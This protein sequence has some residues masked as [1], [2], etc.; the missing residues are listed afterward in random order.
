[1]K[2]PNTCVDFTSTLNF[3]HTYQLILMNERLCNLD[4]WQTGFS[5]THNWLLLTQHPTSKSV[6][7]LVHASV[8]ETS[9]RLK[10]SVLFVCLILNVEIECGCVLSWIGVTTC[11]PLVQRM[12]LAHGVLVQWIH[13]FIWHTPCPVGSKNLDLSDHTHLCGLLK[14]RKPHGSDWRLFR[15]LLW[16]HPSDH[17]S[18]FL[19]SKKKQ[20]T[21]E[22]K[23]T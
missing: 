1:M 18:R 16:I 5:H 21:W 7:S 3:M 23:K 19:N 17:L 13:F 12:I 2:Y 4:K 20:M 15:R 22:N 9:V 10:K 8:S 11:I 6:Q 14:K